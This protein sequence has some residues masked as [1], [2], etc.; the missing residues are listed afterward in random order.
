VSDFLPSNPRLDKIVLEETS[1][2]DASFERLKAALH[3]EVAGEG[4]PPQA[5]V[6][7]AKTVLPVA[8]SGGTHY[9]VIYP[10]QNDRYEL[11]GFSEAELDEKERTIRAAFGGQ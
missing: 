11:T 1:G 8:Q 5:P 7:P 3:A 2:S 10:H 4:A 6:L 9:R